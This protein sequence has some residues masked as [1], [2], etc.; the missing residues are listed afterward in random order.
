MLDEAV[1]VSAP[2]SPNVTKLKEQLSVLQGA[3]ITNEM[4]WRDI[5]RVTV[6]DKAL[7]QE[8]ISQLKPFVWGLVRDAYG[9]PSDDNEPEI[10]RQ[11]LSFSFSDIK[12]LYLKHEDGKV[13]AYVAEQPL[14]E[15]PTE[16]IVADINVQT[17]KRGKGI[18]AELYQWVLDG[19][20]EAIIGAS[21]NPSALTLRYRSSR[22]HGYDCVFAPVGQQTDDIE[23]LKAVNIADLRSKGVLIDE[24]LP[25][26][27]EGCI[28]VKPDYLPPLDEAGLAAL[29]GHPFEDAAKKIYELQKKYG[30]GEN[31]RASVIGHFF[32]VDKMR[33]RKSEFHRAQMSH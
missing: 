16:A 2:E 24:P 14:K 31:A 7:W 9:K 23:R 11:Q 1:P 8:N 17:D 21:V 25:E 29:T 27:Y 6:R 26:G 4:P 30:L 22:L 18:G 15:D 33:I 32:S 12:N 13:V 20:Y 19:R 5:I 28:L 10:I 3:A